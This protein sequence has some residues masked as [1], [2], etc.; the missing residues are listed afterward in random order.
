LNRLTFSL[1]PGCG[2]FQVG[3]SLPDS[4]YDSLEYYPILFNLRQQRRG[5][6]AQRV[7]EM[8]VA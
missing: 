3:R 1:K 2:L 8:L 4:I 5:E 6:L 7:I